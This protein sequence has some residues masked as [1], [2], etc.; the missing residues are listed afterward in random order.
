MLIGR[1]RLLCLNI[2]LNFVHDSEV[3]NAYYRYSQRILHLIIIMKEASGPF[4]TALCASRV[5]NVFYAR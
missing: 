3:R 5:C 4:K 1:S 2:V